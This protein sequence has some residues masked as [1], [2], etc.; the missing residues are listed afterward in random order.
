MPQKSCTYD[1]IQPGGYMP[2]HVLSN[3]PELELDKHANC[4]RIESN[5]QPTH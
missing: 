4:Y 3:D 2:Y 5:E 1:S